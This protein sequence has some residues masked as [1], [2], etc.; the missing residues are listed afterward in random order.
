MLVETVLTGDDSFYIRQ[1]S[2]EG[3]E[4]A[5]LDWGCERLGRDKLLDL[6]C[7]SCSASTREENWVLAVFST[8]FPPFQNCQWTT[9]W[10]CATK[11]DSRRFAAQHNKWLRRRDA[12]QEAEGARR[13]A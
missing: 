4:Q 7:G 6:A 5:R 1:Q 8:P 2:G 12:T 3:V 10:R 9:R 11:E 13:T